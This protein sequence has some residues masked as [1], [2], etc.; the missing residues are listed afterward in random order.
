MV[1]AFVSGI[2][3][4]AFGG[5][6]YP[7][8]S[9]Q[10]IGLF[11][12]SG[13]LWTLFA[14]QQAFSLFTDTTNRLFPVEY[15]RSKEMCILFAQA[16][17]SISCVFVPIYFIPLFF[18]FVY[19]DSALEAGI[20][21]LPFVFILVFAAML[22]GGMMAK[23]GY[24]LPWFTFGGL[25]V[26]AGGALLYSVKLNSATS[27]VYGYSV[28]AAFGAGLYT[29]APFSIAQA[30]VEWY[31]VSRVTAFINCGQISGIVLSLAISSSIYINQATQKIT[32]ILPDIP[33]DVVQEAVTGGKASFFQ[34]LSPTDRL[35]VLVAIV[36]TIGNIYI[37]V[38][39][40]GALTVILSLFMRW[41]KLF[42][43]APKLKSQNR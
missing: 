14:I 3:A 1:G 33:Y 7:W 22:N 34:N 36:S 27:T 31:L 35:K 16:S 4:I 37:L 29:Q 10:I 30:K 9:G 19:N 13:V 41:E 24:Y 28:V 2:M 42:L 38:I 40:G 8:R 32:A 43:V 20:R 12:C 39:A 5:A 25:L 17:A 15:I 18:Q 11:I 23:F 26:T 21:L 6:L